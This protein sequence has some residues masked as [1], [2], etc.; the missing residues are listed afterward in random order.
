M[1]WEQLGPLW[2]LG[3]G[4]NYKNGQIKSILDIGVIL[5]LS[6]Q[7]MC[8]CLSRHPVIYTDI[9]T[10]THAETRWQRTVFRHAADVW[11]NET[12]GV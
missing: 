6:R 1:F 3:G 8:L 7:R 2:D 4:D 9:S 11:D 10:R 12:G 5:R